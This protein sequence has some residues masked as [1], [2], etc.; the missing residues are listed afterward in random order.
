VS[1][2]FGFTPDTYP[3]DPFILAGKISSDAVLAYHTALQF[4]G[5]AHS[6]REEMIFLTGKAIRPMT[7]RGYEY[8]G[9]AFPKPL[10]DKK[11][12]LFAVNVV[13]R[14]G[15][16]IKLTSLERTLVDLLD[17]PIFGGGWEEIWRSLEAVEFFDVDKVIDYAR[18]LGNATTVAKVGF[19]LEQHRKDLMV[20]DSHLERLREGV[21]KQPTYMSRNVRG[22]LVKKWN[23]LVSEQILY[24]SWEETY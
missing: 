21:P 1:V 22:R 13:E 18:L 5:K 23:L 20:D 15:I 8:R 2:P 4:F 7:F 6:V 19:Y 14:T 11:Q 10:V 24:R 16:A 17:R 12:E 3:V 9:V